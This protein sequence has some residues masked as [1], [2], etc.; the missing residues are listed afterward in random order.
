MTL[1]GVYW[2]KK[3]LFLFEHTK[4]NLQKADLRGGG[5]NPFGQ[6]GRKIF[7]FFLTTPLIV[8]LKNLKCEWNY[9]PAKIHEH[10][11]VRATP[12]SSD[13]N[14]L[15]NQHYHHFLHHLHHL[16]HVQDPSAPEVPGHLLWKSWSHC[17]RLQLR[18]PRVS[19]R[20]GAKSHFYIDFNLIIEGFLLLGH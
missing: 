9:F 10:L 3:H 20:W 7:G 19:H 1:R 15:N 4:R 14:N 16:H 6:P 5:V 18:H 8:K 11:K 13:H 17:R 12:P 2:T